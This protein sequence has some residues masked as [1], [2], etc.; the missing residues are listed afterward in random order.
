[1]KAGQAQEQCVDVSSTNTPEGSNCACSEQQLPVANRSQ[2]GSA[3][4]YNSRAL[5]LFPTLVLWL[6]QEVKM[7]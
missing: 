6:D 5:P 4:V 3:G 2:P 1:M 7:C